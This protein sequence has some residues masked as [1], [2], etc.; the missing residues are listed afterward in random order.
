[1]KRVKMKRV[2]G[3]PNLACLAF[4]ITLSAAISIDLTEELRAFEGEKASEIFVQAPRPFQE[5]NSFRK[6]GNLLYH[7]RAGPSPVTIDIEVADEAKEWMRG[8]MHR[9]SMKNTQG[10]LFIFD[11]EKKWSFW[12]K[13]THIPLDIVFIGAD[14]RIVDIQ[15]NTQPLSTQS[16]PSRRPC[17]YVVEVNAGFTKTHRIRRGDLVEFTLFEQQRLPD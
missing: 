13:K 1:M 14:K 8:L 7:V 4:L 3:K 6:E 15:A 5:E 10:M 16:I 11:T 12:M 17:R 9:M 2:D